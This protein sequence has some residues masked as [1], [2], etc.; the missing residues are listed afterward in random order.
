MRLV[1]CLLISSFLFLPDFLFQANFSMAS[2]ERWAPKERGIPSACPAQCASS[3]FHVSFPSALPL[4]SCASPFYS[5]AKN[6]LSGEHRGCHPW[7]WG[8]PGRFK[9]LAPCDWSVSLGKK[10]SWRFENQPK[11]RSGDCCHVPSASLAPA[12]A[13]SRAEVCSP[14]LRWARLVPFQYSPQEPAYPGLPPRQQKSLWSWECTP[15]GQRHCSPPAPA[16]TIPWSWPGLWPWGPCLWELGS[17]RVPRGR[18]G[19]GYV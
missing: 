18:R 14:L 8:S 6:G 9:F 17:N 19:P 7:L 10:L 5:K 3:C 16:L 11:K 1:F 15:C 12:I 4:T 2:R 13:E